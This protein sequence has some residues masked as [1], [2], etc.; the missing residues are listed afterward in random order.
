VC[1]VG[2]HENEFAVLQFLSHTGNYVLARTRGVHSAVHFTEAHDRL[3]PLGAFVLIRASAIAHFG[4]GCLKFWIRG[5]LRYPD[6]AVS[7]AIESQFHAYAAVRV[8]TK[9]S[10]VVVRVVHAHI[11][12]YRI[13]EGSRVVASAISAEGFTANVHAA[14]Q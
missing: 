14:R 4:I 6:D 8:K 11:E 3:V 13:M 5:S 10:Q 2:R 12:D 9:N 7:G 1:I